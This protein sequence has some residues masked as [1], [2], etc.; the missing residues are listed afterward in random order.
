MKSATQSKK[1]YRNPQTEKEE[2]AVLQTHLIMLEQQ[3]NETADKNHYQQS[4]LAVSYRL[5]VQ[6]LNLIFEV[7]S[8]ELK[9]YQGDLPTSFVSVENAIAKYISKCLHDV[10]DKKR[11]ISH[12]QALLREYKAVRCV[13]G[14]SPSV[15][16]LAVHLI[17][18]DN[19]RG[20]SLC[21]LF[22]VFLAGHLGVI[23]KTITF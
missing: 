14:E 22:N 4:R 15:S 7:L 2:K 12:V 17:L 20:S 21:K 3:S 8:N 1:G 11:G 10:P 6:Q 16:L 9:E 23:T 5:G 13:R 19:Y 18:Q